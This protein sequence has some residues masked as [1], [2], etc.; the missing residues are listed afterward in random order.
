MIL[1]RLMFINRTTRPNSLR[2]RGT[3]NGCATVRRFE[4]GSGVRFFPVVLIRTIR[5]VASIW[6]LL[7]LLCTSVSAQVL[8][9]SDDG[10]PVVGDPDY[11]ENQDRRAGPQ[12]Q[13]EALPDTFGIFNYLVDNPNR[14]RAWRDSLLFGLQRYEPDRRAPFDYGTI[15]Q[16]GGAAYRLRYEPDHRNGTETGLRQYDLYQVDGSNLPF[17]RLERAYTYLGH[18]RESQQE[19]NWTTAKFSRNFADGVNL[20]L[21]YTRISQ[22]GTQDQYPNQSLRNTHVATGF[23]YRPAG[24][25]YSGYYSYA[26]NTYEQLQNGGLVLESLLNSRENE[27]INLQTLESQL[28]ETRLRHSYRELMVT[29]YLQFGGARDTLTGRDRRAFTLRHQAR[30]DRRRYRVSSVQ[31]PTAVDSFFRRFP[32]LLVDPRGIRS[33]IDH[34]VLSNDIAFSTFRKGS[35]GANESVQRD[36][37]EAGLTHQFNRLFQDRDSTVNHLLLHGKLGF[38][39]N[40]RLSLIVNGQLNIL[41][42]IGDYRLTGEGE[43]DLGRAGKLELR[44]LNQLYRPDLTKQVYRLNGTTLWDNDFTQTLEVRLEGAYT[45]P[46][47]KIKAGLAYSLLTNYVYFGTDGLPRQDGNAN[48]IIQLTAERDLRINHLHVDNRVL[49]QQ[50]DQSVFRLPQLYGEH[51]VYYVG[52]WFG[53]LNVNFGLDLRYSSGYQPYYYNPITQ[54]FQLQEDQEVGFQYQIDPFFGLRVTRFRF[55]VKYIQ[56]NT[57]WD[58]DRLFYLAAS[59]PN[60]DAAVRLGITWRLLD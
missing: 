48:S 23:T 35:S 1:N 7:T 18:V 13:R 28:S 27:I 15:G 46:L 26:A 8:D 38:R 20:M 32:D 33:Q 4:P 43:L 30:Y 42:Q 54:Q 17:Y 53:V 37:V 16:T 25:R 39:P 58:P 14:E 34:T 12:D 36:V 47:V 29:Q 44:A 50:A 6:L 57:Q 21:D 51:S 49:F 3:Q 24:A 55:F 60:P 5:S 19:D 59:S 52:K 40:D 31:R 10:R 45:L 56:L 2:R 22:Q 41:G 9:P 11:D